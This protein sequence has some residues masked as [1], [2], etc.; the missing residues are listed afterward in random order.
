MKADTIR[1]HTDP[2]VYVILRPEVRD[3]LR[4]HF[5]GDLP[6]S[7]FYAA[8]PD[9][10]LQS[11]LDRFPNAVRNARPNADGI[12][13]VSVEFDTPI[14]T[15]NVVPLES[16]T[17]DERATL[18]TVPRGETLARCASC[19]RIFPTC[20]CQLILDA[21]SALITAY[22]GPLAPPLPPSPDTPDPYWDHHVF[23]E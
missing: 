11:V 15:S 5:D 3:H 19:S 4:R 16:L 1:S 9:E 18:R 7:K 10:L 8:T 2:S 6:G 23:I 22:P 20:H 12:K 17:D 13:I 21:V 14:G